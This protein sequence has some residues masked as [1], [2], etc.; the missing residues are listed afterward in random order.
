MYDWTVKQE[1]GGSPSRAPA[2]H[3]GR[4]RED[5]PREAGA[6]GAGGAGTHGAKTNG[7]ASLK[8][9]EAESHRMSEGGAGADLS[10]RRMPHARDFA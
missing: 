9:N 5:A 1:Q 4:E 10:G 6:S 2:A 7:N 3:N 8:A